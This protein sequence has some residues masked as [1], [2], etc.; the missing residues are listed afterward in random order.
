MPEACSNS[1]AGLCQGAAEVAQK[2]CTQKRVPG[3]AVSTA[4][5][6]IGKSLIPHDSRRRT[7]HRSY[8]LLSC[9]IYLKAVS[10]RLVRQSRRVNE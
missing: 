7:S 2:V 1:A 5:N 3:F 6:S 8:S 9:S 10:W 4:R